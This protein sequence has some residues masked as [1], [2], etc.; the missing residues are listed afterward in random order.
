MKFVYQYPDLMEICQ[1][2]NLNTAV[3]EQYEVWRSYV[4]GGRSALEAYLKQHLHKYKA[5]LNIVTLAG[6]QTNYLDIYL[7]LGFKLVKSSFNYHDAHNGSGTVNFLLMED[8]SQPLR[9]ENSILEKDPSLISIRRECSYYSHLSQASTCGMGLMTPK[10]WPPKSENTMRFP[11][12]YFSLIRE[13]LDN[14]ATPEAIGFLADNNFELLCKTSIASYYVNGKNPAD[15]LGN[16]FWEK[17]CE[18]RR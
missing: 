2:T 13:P 8:P 1:C 5:Q 15:I 12:N 14:L 6:H 10:E 16:D 7:S 18:H 3:K 17:L 11:L 4:A 9:T